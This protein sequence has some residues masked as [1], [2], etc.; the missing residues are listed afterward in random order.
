MMGE[1]KD[2]TLKSLIP[3]VMVENV[4]QT[5]DYYRDNLGFEFVQ[6]V[7]ENGQFDWA[8]M[9]HG[10][11][12]LMFQSQESLGKDVPALKGHRPG[13]SLTFYI[14]VNDIGGLYEELKKKEVEIVVELNKTF[15][16]ATELTIRDLNGYYLM[17]SEMDD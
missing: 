13:G 3:N 10:D 5:V 6:S 9:Q 2:I 14:R 16:G 15:Y 7:P 1:K 12:V 8:M 17:F 11:V 4:N